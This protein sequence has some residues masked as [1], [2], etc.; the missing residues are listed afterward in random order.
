MAVAHKTVKVELLGRDRV[1]S[2]FYIQDPG[3]PQAMVVDLK[4]DA[5]G[6]SLFMNRLAQL[7]R[8]LLSLPVGDRM[9]LL[10]SS[11]QPISSTLNDFYRRLD[12]RD[13]ISILLRELILKLQNRFQLPFEEAEL[14]HCRVVPTDVVDRAI[15]GGCHTTS[16][17]ARATSAGTSCGTCKPD[18][19]RLISYRLKS[20]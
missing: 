1:A 3:T 9:Q 12:G 10:D 11:A 18:T 8:D 5:S 17:V 2:E 19:D 15:I 20:L 13:H 7:R 6:C 4:L 16:S 14:C